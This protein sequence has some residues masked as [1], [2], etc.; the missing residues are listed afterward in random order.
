MGIA[1]GILA[2]GVA[3]ADSPGSR[4]LLADVERSAERALHAARGAF[5]ALILCVFEPVAIGIALHTGRALVGTIGA[6]QKREYTAIA[7]AVNLAARLEELNKTF[8]ASIVASEAVIQAAG[9]A[10]CAGFLGPVVVPIRGHDAP[11]A[12]RYLPFAS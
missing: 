10:E 12:V 4:A 2:A 11:L 3:R 7:D 5:L 6:E 9:T 1:R 8:P